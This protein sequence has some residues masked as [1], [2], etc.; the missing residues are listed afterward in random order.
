MRSRKNKYKFFKKGCKDELAVIKFKLSKVVLILIA[1]GIIITAIVPVKVITTK[2]GAKENKA[3]SN[4]EEVNENVT[5]VES[6]YIDESGATVIDVDDEENPI[7]IPVPKGYSASKIPGETS[8]NSGFVIYEGDIDWNTILVGTTTANSIDTQSITEGENTVNDEVIQEQNTENIISETGEI[9]T[10]SEETQSEE[11][12]T[13]SE[14]EIATNGEETQ[15]KEGNTQSEEEI[16][17]NSEETQSKEENTQT[18]ETIQTYANETT[19]TEGTDT[20][21]TDTES[22]NIETREITQEEINIFNL[23]KSANQYV[24]VPVKDITRIYGVD[25]NGKLWGKLYNFPTSDTESRTPLNW[26]EISSIMSISSKTSNSEPDVTHDITNYDIVS[27]LQSYLDGRTQQELL[28]KE[29]E[30]NFYETIKSIEEYG[31][32]YIGRYETGGL[33]GTAVVR[34]MG[35][36]IAR[37]TWY[38]MY[39]KTKTLS[40]T[41][42]NVITSMIWGSLWDETLQWLVDSEATISDGTTMSYTLLENPTIWGNCRDSTFY[43]ISLESEIPEAT[44]EKVI[45]ETAV[46]PAGSTD[47]TK[48]NNIYD[49]AGNTRESTLEVNFTDTRVSRGGSFNV[50]GSSGAAR[51]SNNPTYIHTGVGSRSMLLI[52]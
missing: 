45:D 1:I 48:V 7:K 39:E 31:G 11:E 43:Y 20:E 16:T 44:V 38:T 32:F 36:N 50:I 47:Y 21:N 51:Y 22:T 8:A 19:D 25:S 34:K 23:Q 24:W 9:T 33:N 35:T 46:I 5:W 6:T 27:R 14:G 2:V 15:S 40:G 10:K 18:E 52:K 42:E 17:T 30:K 49:L 3:L 4:G 41:H 29:L 28:A 12:N 37:Q 13:Q 26:T